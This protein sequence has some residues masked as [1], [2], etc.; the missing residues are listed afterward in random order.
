[1]NNIKPNNAK[2]RGPVSQH[3]VCLDERTP[4]ELPAS[5]EAGASWLLL[6]SLELTPWGLELN[7]EVKAFISVR[8][9][10]SLESWRLVSYKYFL[11]A[12]WLDLLPFFFLAEMPVLQYCSLRTL[13]WW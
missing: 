2:V 7:A 9:E 8:V 3:L 13:Q 1:M 4:K 5:P 10:E 6:A 12:A 11:L